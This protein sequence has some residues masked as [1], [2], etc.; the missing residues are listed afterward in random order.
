[1]KLNCGFLKPLRQVLRY[2]LSSRLVAVREATH[3]GHDAEDVVVER[4]DADLGRADTDD[5]VE[6]HRELERGLVDARE[7]ARSGRLVLL[8]AQRERVHVNARRRRAGVVLV[9]LHLVEVRA[10]AL[11]EAVLAVELE[12]GDLHGVLALA[13]HA[14]V[15]DDLG[16]QVVNTRLELRNS[17]EVVRVRAEE[18]RTLGTGGLAQYRRGQRHRGR[19]RGL[20]S[21]RATRRLGQQ[22]RNHAVRGE[23]VGVVE[24]LR[25]ANRGEPLGR[26]AV[27]E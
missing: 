4:V 25:T 6:R 8:G 14:R 26:R 23:V 21:D 22:R 11:R 18:R 13:A 17:T 15:E 16:E 12:L 5:R 9:R 27:N 10:L 24:G 19:V 20:A 2:R 3:A 7:V 1:L